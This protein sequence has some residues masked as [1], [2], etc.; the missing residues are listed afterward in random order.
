[1]K[2]RIATGVATFLFVAALAIPNAAGATVDDESVDDDVPMH[3]G[4]Q[5]EFSY[6]DGL[7]EDEYY[8][9][10]E[11]EQLELKVREEP[12]NNDEITGLVPSEQVA[13][14]NAVN[15]FSD[16][17][18]GLA[19]KYPDVF[20]TF[21]VDHTVETVEVGVA[22]NSTQ[23]RRDSF[24]AEVS[25]IL[26]RFPYEFT[27][28]SK[29][30]ALAPLKAVAEELT[31]DFGLWEPRFGGGSYAANPDVEPGLSGLLQKAGPTVSGRILSTRV[32]K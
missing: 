1:M 17:I 9:L 31:G 21:I 25:S 2:R 10:T 23:E 14:S 22:Q 26:S 18:F 7:G 24:V 12:A 3:S 11:Q 30:F 27:L 4:P 28:P 20:S 29:E 32:R 13:F 19:V 8:S 6:P 16:P 5:I 15:E